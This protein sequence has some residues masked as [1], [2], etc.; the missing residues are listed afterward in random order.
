M[1]KELVKLANHLDSK[2]FVK[3]ADYLDR[4]IKKANFKYNHKDYDR[5]DEL[6]LV[7]IEVK[8]G[9]LPGTGDSSE[10][11]NGFYATVILNYSEQY[12]TTKLDPDQRKEFDDAPGQGMD[13]GKA[14]HEK[15]QEAIRLAIESAKSPGPL[16]YY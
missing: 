13:I 3:E 9:R 2:G 14:Y 16:P 10:P 1:F 11:D 7:T 6:G 4:I 12:L 15:A 5:Y 8:P